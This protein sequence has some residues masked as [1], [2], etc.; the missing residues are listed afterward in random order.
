MRPTD[1]P[2]SLTPD[3]RFSEVARILA[4]GVLRLHGRAAL[5][6]KTAEDSASENSPNSAAQGLEVSEETVL[7]VHNG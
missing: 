4:A 2:S 5:S 7:S 6:A 1:D 3:E